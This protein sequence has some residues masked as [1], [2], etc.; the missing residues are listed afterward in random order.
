MKKTKQTL[1][2][3]NGLSRL[4]FALVFIASV[5]ISGCGQKGPLYIPESSSEQQT[6]D[7]ES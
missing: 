4:G 3:G 1:R 5:I 7:D 2:F 6:Q